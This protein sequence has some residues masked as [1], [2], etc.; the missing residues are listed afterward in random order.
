MKLFS[1]PSAALLVLA[2]GTCFT[3]AGLEP[4]DELKVTLRGINAA[5]HERVNGDYQIGESGSVHLPLL[6]KPVNARGLTSEQF[7][8]AAEAAYKAEGIYTTPTIEAKALKGGEGAI[9]PTLISVGGQVKKGGQTPYQKGMTVIQA[10]DAAGG[11]NEFA[12][13]NLYLIRDGKQYCI[14]FT[15]L[16]HKNIELRPN[17]SLQ[18]SQKGPLGNLGDN[19]KGKEEALKGLVK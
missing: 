13:R 17:D 7:A 5:E 11:M 6:S 19:W 14:D 4:G 3:L 16:R 15:N 10:I 9:G 18:V 1:N 8:R 12:S 2:G